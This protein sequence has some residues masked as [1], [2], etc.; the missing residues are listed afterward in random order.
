M[1][2]KAWVYPDRQRCIVCRACFG[3]LIVD[4]LYDSWECAGRVDPDAVPPEQWPR[5]HYVPM[6]GGVRRPKVAW[7]DPDDARRYAGQYGK[8]VYRCGYCGQWHLGTLRRPPPAV[9]V[10][11]D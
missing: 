1:R 3:F 7:L 4:G 9:G 8:D 11:V 2:G 10:A 6:P 5:E